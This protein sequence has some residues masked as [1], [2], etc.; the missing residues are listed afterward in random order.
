[1]FMHIE[2]NIYIYIKTNITYI[3]FLYEKNIS[4]NEMK[5]K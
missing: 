2:K 4:L 3:I 1:M 5:L